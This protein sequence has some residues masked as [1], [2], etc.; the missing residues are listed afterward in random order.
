MFELPLAA[1]LPNADDVPKGDDCG[2]VVAGVCPSPN[3]NAPDPEAGVPLGVVVVAA[4]VLVCPN[5]N[6]GVALA[7]VVF[8]AAL[9]VE[10]DVEVPFPNKL[11]GASVALLPNTP[12]LPNTL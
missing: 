1:L 12:L 11:L 7:L 8:A 9:V 2:V 4:G 3:E 6:L 5:K 10:V